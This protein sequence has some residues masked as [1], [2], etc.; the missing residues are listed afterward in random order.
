MLDRHILRL[1]QPAID[2]AAKW[3]LAKGRTADQVTFAG[4][5]AGVG[6]ALLIASGWPL[7][8]L[9]F[10]LASRALDGIDGALARLGDAT[11]RGAFLDISLD[12]IFYA[13]IPLAFAVADPGANALAAAILLAAFVATGA[14]FLAFAVIAEKRG[15]KSSAYPSK[16]F[17]YLGGLTEG[18]E[19]VLCFLAMCWWPQLFPAFAYFYACLCALTVIS[20][21]VEGWNAFGGGAR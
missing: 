1:L 7:A 21:L 18:T 6:A 13:A 17:Y 5:G 14:S 3:S 2:G 10:I 8:G 19:T 20:R 16:S 15:L 11:D 9:M 4:F 12:F